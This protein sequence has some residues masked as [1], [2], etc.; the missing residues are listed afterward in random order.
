MYRTLRRE[1]IFILTGQKHF[2]FRAEVF[3]GNGTGSSNP[4]HGMVDSIADDSDG[5]LGRPV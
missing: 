2:R 1:H 5:E 4:L 3:P